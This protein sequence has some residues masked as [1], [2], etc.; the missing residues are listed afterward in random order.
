VVARC[1][2]FI[3]GWGLDDAIMRCEAYRNAGVDAILIHSKK[4]DFLEIE[5]FLKVWKNR[6]PIILVPTNYH[7]TPIS[8][9]EKYGNDCLKI[10]I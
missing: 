6:H 7:Q 8:D 9:F 4:T 5:S 3:A 1:E 10:V 2:S